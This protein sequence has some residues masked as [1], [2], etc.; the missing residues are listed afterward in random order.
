MSD[1]A[2]PDLFAG[3]EP[4]SMKV[5]LPPTPAC[6]EC[7]LPMDKDHTPEKHEKWAAWRRQYRAHFNSLDW[8]TGSSEHPLEAGQTQ[9]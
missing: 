9:T 3:Q 1:D 6:P 7:R 8:S 4:D 5:I 2:A